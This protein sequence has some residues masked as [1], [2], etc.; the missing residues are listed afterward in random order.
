M[1]GQADEAKVW[2]VAETFKVG[3]TRYDERPRN[4]NRG[5]QA[6]QRGK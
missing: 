5:S 1:I 3:P 4:L 2:I 6:K